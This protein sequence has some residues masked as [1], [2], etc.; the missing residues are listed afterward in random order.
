MRYIRTFK[1]YEDFLESQEAVSGSGRYV[2]DITPGFVFI[3]DEYPDGKYTF[4]NRKSEGDGYKFGDVIYYDGALKSVPWSSYTQSMGQKVG[5]VVIPSNM[6]EDGYARIIAFDEIYHDGGIAEEPPMLSTKPEGGKEGSVLKAYVPAEDGHAS[7][8][9]IYWYDN[10]G[11][12]G[13]SMY[14]PEKQTY[15]D[16]LPVIEFVED[17]GEEPEPLAS[18]SPSKKNDVVMGN[19][20]PE[21]SHDAYIGL[22]IGSFFGTSSNQNQN[23]FGGDPDIINPDNTN[24]KLSSDYSNIISPYTSSYGLNTAFT[25]EVIEDKEGNTGYSLT[26]DISGYTWTKMMVQDFNEYWQQVNNGGRGILEKGVLGGIEPGPSDRDFILPHE[27]AFNYYT[28]GTTAGQWYLP[29]A[30]EMLYM[31]ARAG[32]IDHIMEALG[33]TSLEDDMYE[34]PIYYT[35]TIRYFYDSGPKA[36]NPSENILGSGTF[37]NNGYFLPI[38][39]SRYFHNDLPIEEGEDDS[40][41]LKSAMPST[42]VGWEVYVESIFRDTDVLVRPFAMI[43]DGHIVTEEGNYEYDNQH[44]VLDV[45][46]DEPAPKSPGDDSR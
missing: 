7:S 17:G 40:R 12:N 14:L 32:E 15:Y 5:L 45:Y 36:V 10:S 34:N 46:G 2:E 4:F 25:Q 27:A 1:T 30:G 18:V 16:S 41:G 21:F 11:E 20:S 3:D 39:F 38:T 8:Q 6:T 23:T 31:I 43:K 22:G 26:H 42:I 35:S 33:G 19:G 13:D 28:P 44:R 29:A 9:Y 37:D 24:E